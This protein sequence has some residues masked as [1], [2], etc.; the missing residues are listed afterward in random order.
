MVFKKN[1][2]LVQFI[3]KRGH[4]T[5]YRFPF[6]PMRIMNQISKVKIVIQM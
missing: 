4:L 2:F 1:L 3:G 6:G 5:Q